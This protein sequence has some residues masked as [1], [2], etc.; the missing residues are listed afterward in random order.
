[1]VVE[2]KLYGCKEKLVVGTKKMVVGKIGCRKKNKW[3]WEQNHRMWEQKP[4]DVGTKTYFF[5]NK[6]I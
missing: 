1:M 2:T 5:G 6:N 4:I 3:L